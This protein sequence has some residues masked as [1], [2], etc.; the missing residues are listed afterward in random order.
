M[1][2]DPARDSGSDLRCSLE[3]WGA[4]IVLVTPMLD[5]QKTRSLIEELD[6]RL[7]EAER[8][9]EYVNDRSRQSHFWPDRRRTPRLP[10]ARNDQPQTD[11]TRNNV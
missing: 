9:R 3:P 8:L 11:R 7:L 6:R 5:E 1:R 4:L 2:E 10:I